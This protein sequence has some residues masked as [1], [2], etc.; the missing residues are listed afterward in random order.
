MQPVVVLLA[1]TW[2][3]TSDGSLVEKS[4]GARQEKTVGTVVGTSHGE[5]GKRN[6]VS[7]HT[8]SNA[9][10]WFWWNKYIKTTYTQGEGSYLNWHS[11]E[12]CAKKVTFRVSIKS[13]QGC[14]VKHS[15][16]QILDQSNR[17]FNNMFLK[18]KSGRT[19]I[20]IWLSILKKK[21]KLKSGRIVI[22]IWLLMATIISINLNGKISSWKEV[23][24]NFK[25]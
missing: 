11:Y 10:K 19:A 9:Q 16:E 18:K 4:H 6:V 7:N 2:I 24:G 14:G 23:Y 8:W 15:I 22:W 21:K 5:G 13:W 12:I 20:C 1:N 25:K 17:K 3:Y